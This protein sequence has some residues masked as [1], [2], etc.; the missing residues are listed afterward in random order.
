[1]IRIF[2]IALCWVFVC[3]SQAQ[4]DDTVFASANSDFETGEFSSASRKYLRL[5][6]NGLISSELFFNLGTA[7][8]RDGKPG[9]AMLWMRRA[10]VVRPGMPEAE[11]NLRF[12]RDRLGF[13]EFGQ[14]K[15]DR[16]LRSLPPA[17]GKWLFYSALWLGLIAFAAAFCIVRLRPNRSGF[18]TLAVVCFMFAVVGNRITE[19]AKTHLALENFATI[20]GDSVTAL[21]SPT[22]DAEAVIDLPAGSEVRILQVAGQWIYADI[23]GE[24]RGWIRREQLEQVW[25]VS[26]KTS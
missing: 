19:Y 22:P 21:T 13:L 8:Y 16:A 7:L 3:N 26:F 4:E 17:F 5:A 15:M 20:T 25:P 9:E 11:Q 10:E 18:I 1:M 23:P 2:A 12:L 14:S 24:L 6:E